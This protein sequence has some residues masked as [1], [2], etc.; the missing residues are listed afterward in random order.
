[1]AP[2]NRKHYC[3]ECGWAAKTVCPVH[4]GMSLD[5]G[6]RWRPGRKGS[7]ERLWSLRSTRNRQMPP[8]KRR[9]DVYYGVPKFIQDLGVKVPKETAERYQYYP[10]D[11]PVL[12]DITARGLRQ[13]QRR[14]RN[15]N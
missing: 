15:R 1:M 4:P 12:K 14:R 10:W 5:M 11:V 7:R 8:A 2:S 6:T 3:T 13:R 9:G